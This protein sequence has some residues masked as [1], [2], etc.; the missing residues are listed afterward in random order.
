VGGNAVLGYGFHLDT[1]GSSTIVAR[2]YGTACRIYK[3]DDTYP[4]VEVS[5][6]QL[7]MLARYDGEIRKFLREEG[8]ILLV[9]HENVDEI[10]PKL[11]RSMTPSLHISSTSAHHMIPSDSSFILLK[12]FDDYVT[13]THVSSSSSTK[14]IEKPTLTRDVS[15]HNKGVEPHI[16]TALG[17]WMMGNTNVENNMNAMMFHSEVQLLTLKKFPSYV[18]VRL[19]GLVLARSVKYLSHTDGIG[20]D[21][22]TRLEWWKELRDEIKAHAKVLCCHFV[23]GYSEFC[24]IHNDVCI[25]SAIGTAAEL[26]GIVQSTTT[27]YASNVNLSSPTFQPQIPLPPSTITI[28]P[29][30]A[31]SPSRRTSNQSRETNSADSSNSNVERKSDDTVGGGD[32]RGSGKVLPPLPPSL[33][34]LPPVEHTSSNEFPSALEGYHHHHHHHHNSD[35]SNN[36][37][38]LLGS[39]DY[40]PT[41][42]SSHIKQS[43]HQSQSYDPI[44]PHI[45]LRKSKRKACSATHIPYNHN[46]APFAFMRLVP[47]LVCKRKWVPETILTTTELPTGLLTKGKGRLL[48][49]KVCRPRKALQGESDAVKVSEVLPFVEYDLQRQ[50]ILK[51][52]VLGMNA[53]FGYSCQIEISNDIVIATALCTA[54]YVNALPAP[55]SLQIVRNPSSSFMRNNT[56]GSVNGG[57]NDLT[58][59]NNEQE[60]RLTSLQK[61]IETLQQ[62]NAQLLSSQ[63]ASTSQHILDLPVGSSV[64]GS[65]GGGGGAGAITSHRKRTGSNTVKIHTT[66]T[67]TSIAGDSSI[68]EAEGGIHVKDDNDVDDNDSTRSRSSSSSSSTDTS[69]SESLSDGDDSTSLASPSSSSSSSDD[70]SDDENEDTSDDGHGEESGGGGGTETKPIKLASAKDRPRSA[71]ASSKRSDQLTE[72]VEGNTTSIATAEKKRPKSTKISKEESLATV[73]ATR[74][75]SI[76]DLRLPKKKKEKKA[77]YKDERLPFILEIDD[78]TDADIISVLQDWISPNGVDMVNIGVSEYLSYFSLFITF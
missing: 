64:G 4:R 54:V 27:L 39:N 35:A 53:A 18:Q 58:L 13:A 65:G 59:R 72:L 21:V 61:Q 70:D 57:N 11:S 48:E 73:S 25:L 12:S 67:A 41:S 33:P 22:N 45:S 29:T 26:K 46:T 31:N 75:S 66:T 3:V 60:I 63:I 9:T 37:Y 6:A 2:V 76:A 34:L 10:L 5:R 8:R 30:G 14:I 49:G 55:S 74:H 24:T 71:S 50:I 56:V 51:L 1:E 43:H 42:S 47:C 68:L 20:N 69:S 52:K 36:H 38:P 62:F 7:S 77:V 32:G 23:I 17:E 44:T 40:N 78:E 19:G 15:R 28:D 16:S